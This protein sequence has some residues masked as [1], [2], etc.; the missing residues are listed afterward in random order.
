MQIQIT[1][2]KIEVGAALQEYVEERLQRDIKKYFERAI[3]ADVVFS[4]TRAIFHA[5]IHVNEG[6]G[7]GIEINGEG[8]AD[9]AHAAFDIAAD[10][11]TKQ[12]GRYKERITNHHKRKRAADILDATH[13]LISAE[14]DHSEENAPVIVAEQPHT[15]ATLTVS[16]AVMRMELASI[17]ALMFINSANG[18]FNMV[19]KRQDGNIAWVDPQQQKKVG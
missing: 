15:I 1:G 10:R 11:I 18:H 7:A 12:L 19:Y 3:N 9:D 13:Y 16:E 8:E 5:K 14:D 2:Q 6:T 17:P 4:K